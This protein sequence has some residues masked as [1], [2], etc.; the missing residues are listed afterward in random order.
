MRAS[1]TL[2]IQCDSAE[3]VS[4]LESVLRPDNKVPRGQKFRM[5]RRERSL[6]VSVESEMVKS[7]FTSVNSVL[8]D[9]SLFQE[10]LLLTRSSAAGAPG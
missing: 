5:E 1:L 3:T 4:K 9:A 8:V 7:A 6:V 10:I 2:T